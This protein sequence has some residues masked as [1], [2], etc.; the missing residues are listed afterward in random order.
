MAMNDLL[1]ELT[2]F[3]GRICGPIALDAG[4]DAVQEALIAVFRNLRALREPEALYGWARAIAVREAVRIARKGNRTSPVDL[5]E[6]PS[7]QDVERAVDI[8]D[9]LGRLSPE[10]RA[11]LVLRDVEGLDEASAA[12]LLEVP[13][14][15]VKSRL[16]RARQSFRKAWQP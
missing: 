11:V 8:R 4:P 6:L 5:A 2:P 13:V 12:R 15:T 7:R 9:V 16:A 10:H 14:G 3:L 1:A